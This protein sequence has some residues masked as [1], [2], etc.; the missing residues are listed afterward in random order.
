MTKHPSI[1][2]ADAKSKDKKLTQQK[3]GEWKTYADVIETLSTASHIDKKLFI[4]LR[5]NHDTYEVPLRGGEGDL[6]SRF[7]LSGKRNHSSVFS[8]VLRVNVYDLFF[9]SHYI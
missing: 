4:D 5:G 1:V 2:I 3:V 8:T 9:R 6:F 7:S